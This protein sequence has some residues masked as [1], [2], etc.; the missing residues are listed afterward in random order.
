MFQRD[1][2][3]NYFERINSFNPE[4]S[5]RFVQGF[6]KDT[7]SFNTLKFELIEELIAEATGIESDGELWFK[8]IPFTFN[9]KYFLLS[10]FKSLRIGGTVYS[11]TNSSLSGGKSL[12]FYKAMLHVR[13]DLL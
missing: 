8:K 9:P 13:G 11:E 5:Y 2:W 6:D 10:K 3:F 12:E 1:G 7:I 4:A